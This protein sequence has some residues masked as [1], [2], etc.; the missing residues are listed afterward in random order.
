MSRHQN[1]TY[2]RLHQTRNDGGRGLVGLLAPAHRHLRERRTRDQDGMRRVTEDAQLGRRGD[3]AP[4][5]AG[6]GA[7]RRDDIC[8]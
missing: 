5:R 4:D 2:L 8:R 1:K 6:D 3:L 7:L